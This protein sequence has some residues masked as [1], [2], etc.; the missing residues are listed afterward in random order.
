M[1]FNNNTTCHYLL[2]SSSINPVQQQSGYDLESEKE[3]ALGSDLRFQI[4]PF[5]FSRVFSS[6]P[7]GA[8]TR[9]RRGGYRLDELDHLP[10][11]LSPPFPRR[12]HRVPFSSVVADKDLFQTPRT[13]HS[14][15][16]LST[17][18]KK[19]KKG[20]MSGPKDRG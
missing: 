2:S 5:V 19:K 3:T 7:R 16:S 15:S 1:F 8:R 9:G 14:D 4:F 20:E 10:S 11:F 18:K 17:K 6:S 13:N 12:K